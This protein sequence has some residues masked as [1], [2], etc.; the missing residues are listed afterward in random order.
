MYP[1]GFMMVRKYVVLLSALAA[2]VPGTAL[3]AESFDIGLAANGTRIDAVSVAAD[4]ASAPV[5]VLLGGFKGDDA[6][7]AAVRTAVSAYEKG[8]SRS[9]HLLALP[10]ANP[11]GSAL[12]F[13]PKGTAYRE[14]PE[15]HVLWRWLGAQAADLVLI[16]GDEDFGL[17][18]M[19]GTQK[20]ADMGR[21]PAR[22]WSGETN[23]VASLGTITRSEARTELE[24]R[25]ARSPKQLATE[26]AQHYGRDF[27][28]P[29]YI[30]AVALV[31]RVKLGEL[32]EVRKLV[33]PYVNGSK[34]SLARP[35]SL[36]MAG[37]IV[38]TELARR[39]PDPRYAALVRKVGDLG[40]EPLGQMRESMPYHDGYSDSVFMGTAIVAQAGALT[41]DRRYFDMAERHL[42]FMEQL[43][44]RPDGLYRHRNTADAAW[45]RGNGFA[46]IGL[47][48]TL[49]ELPR[50]H[51][52]YAHALESYR[53][54][55]AALLAHQTRDGLWRNV[56][57][58]PGAFAEFSGTA[59]IGYAMQRG[60]RQGWLTGAGYQR[61]VDRA[62]L[63]VNSRTSSAG[64]M[65][66]VCESTAGLTS[67]DQYLQRAAILGQDPR[68]GAMAMLFATELME[69]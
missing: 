68:G 4:K 9:V 52:G 41:G 49:N 51:A 33:E 13:P 39:T 18:S 46:A 30:G 16:A 53:K 25:R 61:A 62:W 55:M 28:Q 15:S 43:D 42:R 40:F 12:A 7:S 60:L 17:A 50:D 36:I 27:D 19:L 44:L 48:M 8:R 34:D 6:S 69:K 26:L 59:M 35:N 14:Q 66:D 57:N 38:F 58:H 45:G 32:D 24:R 54:L 23:W 22:K 29:W 63:A 1:E 31:A 11:A 56:V 3:A 5:V 20:I 47:A 65:I 37:H 64:T 2:L 67:L 21:I 10:V